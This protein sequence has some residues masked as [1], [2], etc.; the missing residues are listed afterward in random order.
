MVFLNQI[1]PL[2]EW[3]HPLRSG[4]V[5]YCISMALYLMHFK[6]YTLISIISL[7]A[8]GLLS[9]LYVL[10]LKTPRTSEGDYEFISAETVEGIVNDTYQSLGFLVELMKSHEHF[11][12]TAIVLCLVSY[13]ASYMASTSFLWLVVALL[14]S[15]PYVYKS[16]KNQVDSKCRDVEAA[17]IGAFRSAERMIPRASS[18]TKET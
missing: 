1:L 15:L 6:E 11:P 18:I 2:L 12:Y 3:E 17:I 14:F 13:L 10:E 4:G 7:I 5:F 8:L 16:R 9:S